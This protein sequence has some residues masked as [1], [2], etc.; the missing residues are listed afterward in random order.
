M[1]IVQ[2]AEHLGRAYDTVARAARAHGFR[3]RPDGVGGTRH[4]AADWQPLAGLTK[5]EAA[6][7]MGSDYRTVTAAARRY[8]IEFRDGRTE[9]HA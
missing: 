5:G 3:F 2:T 6:A 8:G 7:R 9:A 1:T 4:T